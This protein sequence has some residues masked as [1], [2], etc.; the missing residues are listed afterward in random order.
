MLIPLV[1]VLLSPFLRRAQHLRTFFL[2][3]IISVVWMLGDETPLYRLVY[4]H[5]PRFVRG[6]L[7][8]EFALMAFCMFAFSRC[9][10][11]SSFMASPFFY[12]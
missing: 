1:L 9:C 8:A 6:A 7:Y 5:L 3:T 10:G 12:K 2:F 11:S 4:A